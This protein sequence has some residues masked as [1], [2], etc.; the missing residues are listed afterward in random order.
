MSDFAVNRIL[1]VEGDTLPALARREVL[2]AAGYEVTVAHTGERAL[3][4]VSDSFISGLV[5]MDIDLGRGM[6][7]AETAQRLLEKTSLPVVFL[8]SHNE[9]DL[10]TRTEN[11]SSYGFIQKETENTILLASIRTAFE[12][13]AA[14]T[15]TSASPQER[16]Q[17]A[18]RHYLEKELY[19]LVR[20]DH[21]V[22]SFLREGSLDG[23]WYWDLEKPENEWMDSRFWELFGYDPETKSHDPAEWQDLIH[24]EDLQVALDNFHKHLEDP[25]HAYDQVVRYTHKDGK[26]VYVRCRGLAIR[27]ETGRPIRMLG[28]HNDLTGLM[29]TINAEKTLRQELN[30]RVKNNLA[31]VQSLIQLKQY[32][33]EGSTDLS[34]LL[35]QVDTIR[36]LH[37]Q[38]QASDELTTLELKPYLRS[39]ISPVLHSGVKVDISG[40]DLEVS[41]K[42][43]VPLGLVVNELATNASKHGFSEDYEKRFIVQIIKLSGGENRSRIIVSNTGAPFPPHVDVY[44]APSLG[45]RLVS[46]LVDQLGSSLTF[47]RKPHPTFEF[48]VEYESIR[49]PSAP[50]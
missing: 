49:V 3:E 24:P 7:G 22:F 29:N 41:S 25:S 47:R 36:M 11:I 37:E 13:W 35:H 50:L 19:D 26:T 1:H 9:P 48:D 20:S 42:V 4:I 43:A 15:N 10:L 34:D 8:V 40:P 45:L 38:L 18:E 44:N 31:I 39:I 27:D 21:A 33:V 28:V 23:M 5:L 12:L 32:E 16:T 30:H 14:R 46:S 6:D 17:K 2:E